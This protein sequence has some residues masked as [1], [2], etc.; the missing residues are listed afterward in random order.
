MLC[1]V[2]ARPTCTVAASPDNVCVPIWVQVNPLADSN[3]VSVDP[4][5][6]S[7]TH[8]GTAD[9]LPAVCTDSPLV[10]GRRW[11]ATPLPA[12]TS[13]DACRAPAANDSRTITPALAHSSEFANDATRATNCPSPVHGCDTNRN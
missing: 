7:F 13:T 5:R 8:R 1:E 12:V 4:D 3:P 10:T 9:P 6:T 2:T 11:N